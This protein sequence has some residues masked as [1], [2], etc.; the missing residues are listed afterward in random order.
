M[1][2][3]ARLEAGEDVGRGEMRGK[4]GRKATVWGREKKLLPTIFD[5]NGGLCM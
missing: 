1:G 4:L 5:R 3:T 2:W